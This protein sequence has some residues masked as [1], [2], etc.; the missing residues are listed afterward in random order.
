MNP[1][2]SAAV[3]GRSGVWNWQAL[4]VRALPILIVA[5]GM[6]FALLQHVAPALL[7][8]AALVAFLLGIPHGAVERDP[9][10]APMRGRALSPS[11]AYSALYLVVG[12]VVFGAW[13][14]VP[15]P[16][17]IIALSLSAWHFALPAREPWGVGLFVVGACFAAYPQVTL[18]LFSVLTGQAAS[19]PDPL[20]RALG[21][22]GF[23]A[24]CMAPGARR[25]WRVRLALSALFLLVHPV[26]AV[27]TYFLVCHSLGETAALLDENAGEPVWRT[28]LRVYG[29]TSLPALMGASALVVATWNGL[30]LLPIAAGLAVAFIVPHMLPVEQLLRAARKAD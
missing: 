24:L 3:A 19:V 13:L 2:L 20:L 7:Y 23:V 16:T 8:P 9:L 22:L 29:P 25:D 28:L 21:L 17:L 27:A 5:A 12:A 1:G 10:G 18:S 26:A 6:T 14:I 30:V 4:H 15:W 11:V